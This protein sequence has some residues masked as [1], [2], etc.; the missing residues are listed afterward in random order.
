[1]K[2]MT[3]ITINDGEI[4]VRGDKIKVI[5]V[6]GSNE[7]KVREFCIMLTNPPKWGSYWAD[8]GTM[9]G[10]LNC[11]CRMYYNPF[12]KLPI[13]VEGEIEKPKREYKPGR[14]Y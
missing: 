11:A 10:A 6:T 3:T 12:H 2:K 13:V 7:E 1:M 5:E 9:F 8:P 4:I 14:I